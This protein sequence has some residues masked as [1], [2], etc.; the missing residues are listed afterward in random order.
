MKHPAWIS[1][2]LN[3]PYTPTASLLVDQWLTTLD[4]QTKPPRPK[5]RKLKVKP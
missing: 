2:L 4:Q 3:R 5:R 1:A